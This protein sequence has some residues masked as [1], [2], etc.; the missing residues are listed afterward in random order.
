[1]QELFTSPPRILLTA[2]TFGY[3]CPNTD[4]SYGGLFTCCGGLQWHL[5]GGP[6]RPLSP[7]GP[8]A[9]CPRKQNT[10]LHCYEMNKQNPN[11]VLVG[12]VWSGRCVCSYFSVIHISHKHHW[13]RKEEQFP[14]SPIPALQEKEQYLCH[15]C[16]SH[17]TLATT[18]EKE[19]GHLLRIS[20]QNSAWSE[21]LCGEFG[22][23]DIKSVSVDVHNTLWTLQ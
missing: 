15:N 5:P 17:H 22:K 3:L 10:M 14:E 8:I 19:N 21:Q 11:T 1:M 7:F 2:G 16:L 13:E 9:N 23:T 6:G 18:L 4:S 12:R 20:R